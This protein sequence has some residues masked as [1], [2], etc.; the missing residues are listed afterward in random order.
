MIPCL[1]SDPST[2]LRAGYGALS[3][4][5]WATSGIYSALYCRQN[6]FLICQD[7]LLM[8]QDLLLVCEDMIQ[9][10]LVLLDRSLILKD[11]FLVLKN[12]LL[13]AQDFVVCHV[14]SLR[15]E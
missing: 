6:L 7:L 3:F 13:I 11:C 4:G 9:A 15:L 14:F 12:R 1:K 8:A 10:L 5:I 2:P